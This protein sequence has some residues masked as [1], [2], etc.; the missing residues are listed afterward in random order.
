ML[1]KTK[2]FDH[3]QDSFKSAL[4]IDDS[5]MTR[6]RE[7]IFFSHFANT[8]QSVTLFPS[9]EDAPKEL[10]TITGDLQLCIRDV[11]NALEYEVI[12][13]NFMHYHNMAT[14]AFALWKVTNDSS[15]ESLELKIKLEA[16]LKLHELKTQHEGGNPPEISIEKVM[17]RINLVIRSNYNFDKYLMLAGYAEKDYRDV[18]NIINRV[19]E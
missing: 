17:K 7:R 19:F 11:T 12:L 5:V 2:Q 14:K 8:M 3:S 16:M 15:Q 9:R 1:L 13:L 6:C 18:D 10:R 4:N